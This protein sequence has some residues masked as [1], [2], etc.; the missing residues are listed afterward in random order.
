MNLN[1]LLK[2]RYSCRSYIDKEVKDEDLALILNNAI[3]APSAGNLQVWRFIIVKDK[4]K[5]EKVAIACLQQKWMA[6]APV[7]IVIVADLKYSKAHYGSRGELYAVQDC[8][9]AASNILLTASSLNLDSCFISAFDEDMLKRTLEI[10]NGLTRYVVI[11][12][13]YSN[14]KPEEK[15]RYNISML[16]SFNSY[17]AGRQDL[18]IFPVKEKSKSFLTKLKEKLIKHAK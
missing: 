2:R 3:L 1:E 16:T 9:L 12:L 15:K 6:Q 5:R 11:T 8:T 4:E 14:E 18:S 17:G 7:H 13:G 10:P